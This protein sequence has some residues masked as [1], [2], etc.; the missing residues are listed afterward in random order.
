MSRPPILV[1]ANLP[2]AVTDD[3][4]TD[5]EL[6]PL[7]QLTDARFAARAAEFEILL[8]NGEGTVSA[9]L[10][11][12]LPHLQLI[13]DFGV[14]YDGID[15]VAAREHGVRVT[16]TP[17]VLTD[18]VADLALG[19]LLATARRIPAAHRFATSGA[20]SHQS[21]PWTTRVS[22]ARLGIVGMGRI[23]A[24]VAR[25]A[26]GFSMPTRY[27]SRHPH[28]GSGLTHEPDLV[29]LASWADMLVVCVP[30]GAD[31]ANLIDAEVLDALG[32]A[33]FLVNVARGSVVDTAAL[34][35]A[36]EQ[37]RLAG[38]GLDVLAGEPEVDPRLRD[39]D[40]VVITPHMASATTRTR[41][42]MAEL[43]VRNVRA[44]EAGSVLP[45]PIPESA[46]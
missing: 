30:G 16:H 8:T 33:G 10:I 27:C 36:L 23:G 29:R 39:R 45:T 44:H 40:D 37:G 43:V 14:G 12:A 35:D 9:D 28:P 41:A 46:G 5:H 4:G 32:P 21:F 1:C 31:T 26:E 3:L 17:D 2:S 20:W 11:N 6:V 22:G 24:A 18:D 42:A 7:E 15:V 25:R 19:L 13:A 34:L 38:A